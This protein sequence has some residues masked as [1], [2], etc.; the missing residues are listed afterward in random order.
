MGGFTTLGCR[1]GSKLC[2]INFDNWSY[3][4]RN[5]GR[6][7]I[8]NLQMPLNAQI[9]DNSAESES[10]NTVRLYIPLQSLPNN[11][12]LAGDENI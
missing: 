11:A 3:R 7:H 2:T 1:Q 10:Q 9:L 5:P 8:Q 4:H 12:I 6:I